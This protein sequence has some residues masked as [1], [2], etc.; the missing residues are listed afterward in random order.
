[1]RRFFLF[2]FLAG[3]L[4]LWA[5][6][7]EADLFSEAESRYLAKNY[8]AAL[9]SYDGFL[10]QY[11]LSSLISDVQY[12]KAVC[13]Y[14][15][16]RYQESSQL[17]HDVGMRYRS[18]RYI[19]YVAFWEG[20]CRYRLKSYEQSV[21]RLGVFLGA[22]K[23]PELTP[24][25]LLYKAL[26]LVALEDPA[27]AVEPLR[28]IVRDHR[29][30]E[31]FQYS[32]VLLASL[33][34]RQKSY[35]ELLEL[36]NGIDPSGFPIERRDLFLLSRAEGLWG[37]GSIEAAAA[38]YRLL[39][40]SSDDVAVT[41]CR[42]LFDAAQ[43]KGDLSA[44]Q[45][46]TKA[47][48]SRFTGAPDVLADLW[49]R[50][51]VETFHKGDLEGAKQLLTK[52][53]ELRKTRP[54]AEAVPVYLAEIALVNKDPDTARSIL[55]EYA[56][57]SG[58][59][60]TAAV[61]R[62]GDIA[63]QG[64]DLSG[65][66]GWYSKFLNLFPDSP[67]M[68]EAGYLLAYIEYRQGKTDEPFAL[69]ARFLKAPGGQYR[70]EFMRLEIAL[71][72]KMGSYKEASV[73]L[74]EYIAQYP[75]DVRSR[76]DYLKVLF[77][78]KDYGGILREANALTARSPALQSA[79]PY[80]YLLCSYLRGLSLVALKDYGAAVF[81]LKGIGTDAAKK[82]GLADILPSAGYYLGWAYVK[83]G[84]FDNAAKILDGL[85]ASYP[86]HELSAKILFLAAWS[87]FSLGEFD[88]AADGFTRAARL[89]GASE[90][91]QKSL[92]LSAKSYV[93][94][95]KLNEAAASFQSILA[96]VPP[97]SYADSALFD[98]AGVLA[99]QGQARQAAETFRSLGQMFPASTLVEDA[100]YR[101]GEV[102]FDAK[103]FTEAGTAF[104]DYRTLYPK[105]KLVD[106]A[107]Y[108]GGESAF[109]LGEKFG[110]VLLWEQL[111][112][113]YPD[114]TLRAVA[115]RK[116]AGV[117]A[118]S[119]DFAVAVKL[120]SQLISEYPDEARAAKADIIVDQLRYQILGFG[121]REAELTAVISRSSGTAKTDAILELAKL[122]IFS[123]DKKVEQGYQ[124][125]QP[126]AKGS[127]ASA[128]ARA[129]SLA[130]EYFYRKAD[131][132]EASRQFLAAAAK[133][134]A[135]PDFTASQIYRA[136][137][138]MSTAKRPDDVRALV[139]RLTDNYPSSPWTAKARV[140]V[141]PSQ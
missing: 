20:L 110:A 36:T 101:R 131:L 116:T 97:S 112:K 35:G 129:L 11:P 46:L 75:D 13:L 24:Q 2:F 64:G 50:V 4:P 23:D 125:I 92:Y 27:G 88:K 26:S 28:S 79:D 96:V 120:Y 9:E 3:T 72:K 133:N 32:A 106:A 135:D 12:R 34:A 40:D 89:E 21:E 54:P 109:G 117:Y 15:L 51:G 78:L 31:V 17:L 56:A 7:S 100:A 19:E 126:L 127:D 83:S 85:S 37:T 38:V 121:D 68:E 77:Q 128:A 25:A 98:Y 71:L 130:G 95:K 74:A 67:R 61:M 73:R 82:A 60:S 90:L 70:R 118:E 52:V 111:I 62:L 119:R 136:A 59:A 80:A 94:A 103:I 122:Y 138:M 45:D 41:A 22:V 102:Y 48:E 137:E 18:T 58:S 84:S 6:S 86:G 91:G 5:V 53:W 87:H 43:R 65:A 114:S 139:K 42:R 134:A 8:A 69:V 105:G 108:W 39:L 66:A 10:R 93:N 124:M 47:A 132:I 104:S 113:N 107:L 33:L 57:G 123:G 14:R 81:N 30:S 115:L 49:A 1:M 29:S 44:M 55:E 63:M 76:I 16:G 140:L 99:V 141:E